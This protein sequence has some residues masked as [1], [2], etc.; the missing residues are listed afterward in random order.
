M[1]SEEH[2]ANLVLQLESI[3]STL[4]YN[5]KDDNSTL[6]SPSFDELDYGE[7]LIANH[8]ILKD[9]ILV[10]DNK[11]AGKLAK[12]SKLLQQKEES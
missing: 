12:K 3:Y 5:G 2:S 8:N 10:V 9:L 4:H 6:N 1:E 7:K 11:I